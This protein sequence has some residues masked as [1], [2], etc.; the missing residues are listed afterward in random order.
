MHTINSIKSAKKWLATAR[1]ARK[2]FAGF[3]LI[4]LLVV[5]A[6]IAILAAM[7]LPALSSAKQKAYR[8]NCMSN[9]KQIGV[10][11]AMYS[12][13]YNALM[14][15]NWP[16]VCVDNK[17]GAAAGGES[18][19]WR[20]HEI[21]RVLGGSSTM[22]GTP[23]SIGSGDGTTAPAGQS[24]SGWWNIGH[25]WE[26]KY[27]ANGKVFYCPAGVPPTINVNMTWAYYDNSSA[28]PSDPYPTTSNPITKGDNEV[29][30]AYDYFPQSKNT[31]AVS[32]ATPFIGPQ[33]SVSQNDLDPS[34]SIFADQTM[35]YDS[36]SHRSGGFSGINA[37]FGDTHAAWQ[38]AK[39]TPLAFNL[40][41]AGTYPWGIT[42][43]AGSIGESAGGG[44]TT[45]RYVHANLQ[46]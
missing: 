30:V 33:P 29:R 7:L 20:T 1:S 45:F 40:T 27:I 17:T 25:L 36:V 3:T 31:Q 19:P 15:C 37:L 11:W 26:N 16:G 23:G 42:S 8:I 14:P 41:S 6:I 28:T 39:R 21:E 24:M 43:A 34:K 46:P 4:E 9:L 44:I 38:S 13:E 32:G 10:G 35:G 18:S 12:T 5:I 2:P 22:S